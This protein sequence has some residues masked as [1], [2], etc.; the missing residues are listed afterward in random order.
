MNGSARKTL[1]WFAIIAQVVGAQVF[2][3]DALP[4][5]QELTAG[6]VVVG[7]PRDFGVALFGL[8]IMQS[9]YWY[10]R[11]LQPEIRFRPRVVLGHVLLCVSEVSFFFVSALATVAAFDHWKRSQFVLWKAMLL[12]SAIFAFFCYKRQLASVGDALLEIRPEH[13]EKPAVEPKAIGKL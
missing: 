12:V 5:Y 8:V 13:P 1:F 4:D 9:A 7:T 10:A 2:F 11:R 6:K 3:W